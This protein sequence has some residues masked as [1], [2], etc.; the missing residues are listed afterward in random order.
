MRPTH[1]LPV[2]A[3]ALVGR[4]AAADQTAKSCNASDVQAAVD[5]AAPGE[6]VNVPA[7]TTTWA[8]AVTIDKGITLRGQGEKATV[9]QGSGRVLDVDLAAMGAFRLTGF[10]FGGGGS[11]GELIAINGRFASLRV[12]HVAFTNPTTRAFIIGY[13]TWPKSLPGI[14]GLFDHVTYTSAQAMP[15]ILYYG[16]DASW[17]APDD[18]GTANALYVEDSTFHWD[19]PGPVSHVVDGEHG[20]RYVVRH[21]KIEN[22]QIQQHDTGSTQQ[23]RSTRKVEVYSN[24]FACTLSDCGWIAIGLRGGTGVIWD[25]VIS[26]NYQNAASTQIYRV[27]ATGSDPWPNRCDATPDRICSTFYSHC[28]GGDHRTCFDSSDCPSIGP[29]VGSCTQSSECPAGSTCVQMDGQAD[30][31]GW[32]CRDQTGRGQDDPNTRV[33]ASSP[34]YWWNNRTPTSSPLG[35]SV[36]TANLPYIKEGRDFCSHDTTSACGTAKPWT[37]T[38]LAYP[39]P[40]ASGGGDP[41]GGVLPDGAAPSVDGSVPTDGGPNGATNGA[42]G[43]SCTSASSRSPTLDTFLLV[44]LALLSSRRARRGKP[45]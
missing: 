43:C 45:S 32:P 25:N 34:L 16:S 12:D 33:Q 20:A 19:T 14:I 11:A 28:S 6:I 22:G 36:A 24:E 41:D 2:L 1:A 35:V 39:H 17:N 30:S 23:A 15:F 21:S 5:A 27:T 8:S 37:Y 44:A 7:C 4:T 3:L 9:I 38:P 31:S 10:G 26:T 42:N 40:L 13:R 29:C 18:Y